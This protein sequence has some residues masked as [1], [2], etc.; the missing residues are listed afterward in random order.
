VTSVELHIGIAQ[1]IYTTTSGHVLCRPTLNTWPRQECRR[2]TRLRARNTVP[3]TRIK[4]L[5]DRCPTR[6]R[7]NLLTPDEDKA[8]ASFSSSR[9][10]MCTDYTTKNNDKAFK[11]W[12]SLSLGGSVMIRPVEYQ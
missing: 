11:L 4:L 3:L 5:S 2:A 6:G 12:A 9:G 8:K 7:T 1:R 10:E